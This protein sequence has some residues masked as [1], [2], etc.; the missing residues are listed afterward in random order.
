MTGLGFESSLYSKVRC[1]SSST[2][3]GAMP[4]TSVSRLLFSAVGR[5]P[6][7]ATGC[8]EDWP[9]DVVVVGCL[10]CLCKLRL[11]LFEWS[12]LGFEKSSGFWDDLLGMYWSKER[13]P[14]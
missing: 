3:G 11:L 10:C 1:E 14:V 4:V 8:V 9:L 6:D 5:M 12:V 2:H 7:G 13:S